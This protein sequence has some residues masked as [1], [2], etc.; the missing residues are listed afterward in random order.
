[1]QISPVI[2]YYVQK[3]KQFRAGA[4]ILSSPGEFFAKSFGEGSVITLLAAP[5]RV[6]L[7][8]E[9][10][11]YHGL[12]VLP[13]AI[14]RRITVAYRPRQD[15]R[16]RAVSDGH[17][18]LRE[19]D[20]TAG[21][22]PDAPGDWVNYL[23]GAAL[24]V[25]FGWTIRNGIDA[26]ITSD[27]PEAAGLSSSSALLTG[28]ALALLAANGI[29]P[30]FADLFRILPEAEHFVGTR[31]GGM[32]H[33]AILASK[34]GCA[35]LVGF[36]PPATAPILIPPAWKFLVAHSLRGAEKSG[37]L[38]AAYNGCRQAGT[39]A[40]EKLGIPSYAA[41]LDCTEPP[42]LEH[43]GEAERRAF[44]HVTGEGTRVREAVKALYEGNATRFGAL[45]TASH[46]SLR[47]QLRVSTPALD[48]M[49]ET[50]LGSGA[51]G[52]RLTGAGFG[53]CAVVLCLPDQVERVRQQLVAD[54]YSKHPEFDEANHL[55]AVEPSA[56]ALS[57]PLRPCR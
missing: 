26:A 39:R 45:L 50:A 10:I 2:R 35:L 19:F 46:E 37:E 18:G 1:M 38:R 34:A 43:L 6:N 22:Q 20:L 55:F 24:A 8:G 5:G 47:D 12:P 23:K 31:G 9:H 28:F 51:L 36:D 29:Q 33:A 53:G 16:V 49:V 21:L 52:A 40:L 48:M 3:P 25:S 44:L 42:K 7:I 4:N 13:M 54:Y 41:A 56:G 15:G 14:G 30:T 11:D 32:D 57:L 27:L 17:P